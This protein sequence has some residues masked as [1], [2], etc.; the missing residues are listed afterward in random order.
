MLYQKKVKNH[1][2][3]R[4]ITGSNYILNNEFILLKLILSILDLLMGLLDNLKL[5]NWLYY[6]SLELLSKEQCKYRG[7]NGSLSQNSDSGTQ[8]FLGH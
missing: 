7:K 2:F 3:V 8:E 5:R 6:I 1:K 4:L